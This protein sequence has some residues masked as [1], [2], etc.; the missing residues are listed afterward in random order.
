MRSIPANVEAE[1]LPVN[2]HTVRKPRG[3]VRTWLKR[4]FR[5]HQEQA[6]K[7]YQF[8]C[9]DNCDGDDDEE[10]DNHDDDDPDSSASKSH[11]QDGGKVFKGVAWLGEVETSIVTRGLACKIM[12]KTY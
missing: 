3:R 11:A 1:R 5:S 12:L 7:K 2:S 8:R 9:N 10:D 6:T 4:E